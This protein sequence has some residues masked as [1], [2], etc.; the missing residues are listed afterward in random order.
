MALGMSTEQ[1]A[2]RKGV[3]RNAVYQAKRSEKDAAASLKQM[4]QMAAAIGRR[5]VY[6]IVPDAPIEQ[7]KHK[8]A[9]RR[10]RA[11]A[12][13]KVG[14]AVWSKDDREGWLN[15][16]VAQHLHDMPSDF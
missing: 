10:S 7:L 9:V 15:D 6:A 5:F 16:I 2:Q 3:S 11:L 1:V 4:E 12:R 14:F 8:Q 13:D